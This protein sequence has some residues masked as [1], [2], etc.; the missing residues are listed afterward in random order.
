MFDFARKRAAGSRSETA[1]DRP[2]SRQPVTIGF[3]QLEGR[4]MLSAGLFLIIIPDQ[5]RPMMTMP[6]P[7]I[8]SFNPESPAST[9]V[10]MTPRTDPSD[11]REPDHP[12]PLSGRFRWRG[13]DRG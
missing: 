4:E 1:A 6:R 5:S 2:R 11:D 12:W 8:G 3:E 7:Y 13:L 9:M 10:A